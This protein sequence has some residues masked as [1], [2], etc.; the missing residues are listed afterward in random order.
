[1]AATVFSLVKKGDLYRLSYLASNETTGLTNITAKVLKPDGTTGTTIPWNGTDP[2]LGFVEGTNGWYYTDIDTTSL[3]EGAWHYVVDSTTRK[4]PAATR[5][6]VVDGTTLDDTVFENLMTNISTVLSDVQNVSSGLP[7]INVK[8]DDIKGVG[9]DTT[10]DSLDAIRNAINAYIGSGG[11]V[12]TLINALSM[13]ISGVQTVVDGIQT[14]LDNP[15]DGL[16]ALK[17]LIDAIQT[18]IDNG[19]YGLGAIKTAI[20]GNYNLLVDSGYGLSAIKDAVDLIISSGVTADLSSIKGVGYDVLTDGLKA[21]S[22]RTQFG[23]IA[24]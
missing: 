20:D 11:T 1:M 13:D 21:I 22:D 12:P 9:F 16:G 4:S 15:T 2:L 10:D 7:A 3:D 24:F 23:G 6:Q 5:I 17:T 14:D 19:T 18:D 8:L